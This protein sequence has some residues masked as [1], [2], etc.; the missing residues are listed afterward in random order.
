MRAIQIERF[1]GPEVLAEA[2]VPEPTPT[3]GKVLIDV[4]A[5]GINY[6]DTHRVADDYLADRELTSSQ[7]KRGVGTL[8]DGSTASIQVAS[9]SI[10]RTRARRA[11]GTPSARCGC[12]SGGTEPRPRSA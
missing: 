12:S 6:A 7:A 4:T 10:S 5:A 2:D 9:T 1:G 8:E 3:P 11:A